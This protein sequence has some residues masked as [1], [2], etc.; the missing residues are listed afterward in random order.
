M[1][2]RSST[3]ISKSPRNK[4]L[5][6]YTRYNKGTVPFFDRNVFDLRVSLRA[7][8]TLLPNMVGILLATVFNHMF[9]GLPAVVYGDGSRVKLS[10]P[11]SKRVF[12]GEVERSL[13]ED[14][15]PMM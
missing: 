1:T 2:L 10:L 14:P 6:I 7:L 8:T 13:R 12:S 3:T 5:G 4:T 9:H 11:H 15:N